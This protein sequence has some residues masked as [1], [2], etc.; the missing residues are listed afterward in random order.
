MKHYRINKLAAPGGAI[1]KRKDI[2]ANDAKQAV[3][4]AARDPDCPICE[5]WHAGEKIGGAD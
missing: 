5:V 3:E 4:I 2:L 1:V